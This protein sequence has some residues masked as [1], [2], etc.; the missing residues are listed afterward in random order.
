MTAYAAR[1]LIGLLTPQANTT[2]E[3][4]FAILL[5]PGYAHLN[6]RM[7]S[8]KP[9]IEARLL[10]YIENLAPACAQYAN[11]PLS[12]IA[13]ACTGASYLAGRERE[14]E[15]L[16]ALKASRGIPAYTAATAVVDALRALGTRRI[17]L[18]SPYPAALTAQSIAYWQSQGFEVT[19]VRSAAL[20][21]ARF[22]PIYALPGDAA[23]TLVREMPRERV[24]AILLLGTG[25]PTLRA[26][27]EAGAEAGVPV[28]SCM[29]CLAWK[30][31]DL[32]APAGA[33]IAPWVHGSAWRA[34]YL[35]HTG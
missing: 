34:R 7:I 30:A 19:Q 15:L 18:G 2:V 22:H 16:A 32:L 35:A 21:D 5:P 14:A 23:A 1:G 3:P 29:L 20:D 27:Q 31:V 9:S 17:A 28:I 4:E 11:A 8:D 25:M 26:L 13:V 6:A 33:P 10:D 12:A 24:D